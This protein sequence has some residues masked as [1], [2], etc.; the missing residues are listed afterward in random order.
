MN[1]PGAGGDARK[2]APLQEFDWHLLLVAVVLAGIGVVFI[3][4]TTQ[5]DDSARNVWARQ[6]LYVGVVL[7]LVGAVVRLP[8]SMLARLAFPVY[9]VTCGVLV[10]L[11]L[12]QTD[13]VRSTSSWIRL[14]MGFSL[15][16]SEFAKVAVILTLASYLRFRER[17]KRL[18]DLIG[19][20]VLVGVPMALVMKQPDL[21]SAVLLVPVL[22]AML[23]AAGARS[24]LLVGIGATGLL[25][26]VALYFSPFMHDYQRVRIQSHFQSIPE[27]TREMNALRAA[28]NHKDAAAIDRSLQILKQGPKHQV[29]HAMISIGSGGFL[30]KGIGAGPHN[31][32]DFLPERHN[33]F[34]FAV[35]GEEWGFLGST[36]LMSAYLL[37][38]WLILQ[39]ARRTRDAFGRLLCV[40]VATQFG[41]Q[42]FLNTGV[43]TGLLPV[44]G[45]TLPFLS[46]GGSSII[47]SFLALAV[48]LSV[49]AHRVTVLDGRTFRERAIGEE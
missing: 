18:V 34:I 4:S 26:G 49:G 17:P 35:V 44:T 23:F 15:Q 12:R 9:V 19:P 20:F 8:Y 24:R 43:A 27:K 39:V 14:P 31:R 47:A 22:F 37:L 41:G 13:E 2:R 3:W 29:Y 46:A 33:D 10:F 48:V 40:G 5:G 16:P 28:G 21:G 42:I 6:I 11:L 32:L 30:G 36:A 45:V 7:P 25:A 1:R 38:V